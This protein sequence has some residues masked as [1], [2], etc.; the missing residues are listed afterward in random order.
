VNASFRLPA[1]AH[2]LRTHSG[3][4]PTPSSSDLPVSLHISLTAVPVMGSSSGASNLLDMKVQRVA[5]ISSVLPFLLD[6]QPQ[7]L[8]LH[9]LLAQLVSGEPVN[10]VVAAT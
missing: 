6:A 9:G 3:P 7:I 1:E 8:S 2:V 5:P 10:Q 4:F